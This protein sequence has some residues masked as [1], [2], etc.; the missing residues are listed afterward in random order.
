MSFCCL[1]CVQND[2]FDSIDFNNMSIL[3]NID[4]VNTSLMYNDHNARKAHCM[5]MIYI[6]AAFSIGFD[7]LIHRLNRL[8]DR[9]YFF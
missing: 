4:L 2:A 7:C 8:L 6:S 5:Y 9:S 3:V 1:S